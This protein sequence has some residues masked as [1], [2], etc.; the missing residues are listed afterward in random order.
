MALPWLARR[1]LMPV[2]VACELVLMA[3]LVPV[4]VV[5]V[6][7]GLVDRRFRLLRLAAMGISYIAI[8]LFALALLL[9][10]WLLRPVR[11][12]RWWEETNVGLVA[13]GLGC[14][15]GAA[16]RTV[17]FRISLQEPPPD[18]GAMALLAGP[19]PVLVLARH[20]GIGD[21]F[22]LVWLLAARYRRR[23]RIVVKDILLW[24][25]LVDVALTRMKACF[26]PRSARRGE[27]LEARVSALSAGLEPGEALLLFPEGANW[28][29]RRRLRAMARLWSSG[30]PAAV[31]AAALMEHV[32]P[33]RAGGVMACLAARPD[34]PVVVVAH[35]GLDRI[36]T[37]GALWRSVPFDPAMSVRWWLAPPPPAGQNGRLAWLTA[38]WAV[39]DE[40]IDGQRAAAP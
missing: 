40:W 34:L 6:L 30:K 10:V 13:W 23:P 31:K 39:V 26:L 1:V 16:R 32:L 11:G 19:D 12:R 3:L 22:S 27:A 17:G 20:G 4:V 15:L 37:A 35:T 24:E 5:G 2:W 25:P 8:E 28:T 7:C 38:E 36:T 29:P 18:S 21:S 14:I 9:G 33:P